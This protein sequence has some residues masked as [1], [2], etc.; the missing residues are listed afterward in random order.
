M[1]EIEPIHTVYSSKSK[2]IKSI[3][4]KRHKVLKF[5]ETTVIV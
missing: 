1:N 5:V 2:A 4:A 3:F